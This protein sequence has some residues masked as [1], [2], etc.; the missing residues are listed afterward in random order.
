YQDYVVR[1]NRAVGAGSLLEVAARQEQY[2]ANNAGYASTTAL[3]G[4]GAAYYVDRDGEQGTAASGIYLI[5]VANVTSA[6]ALD[7]TLTAT[8]QNYQ[9]RDTDCGDLTLTDRGVKDQS[10]SGERCWE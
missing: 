4:Y 2:F 8:P 3:L 9:T 5:T 7:F 6:P 1:S 10:G